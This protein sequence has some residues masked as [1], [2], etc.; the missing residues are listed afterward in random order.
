M[1]AV[2]NQNGCHVKL[3]EYLIYNDKV[4]HGTPEEKNEIN[5][6]MVDMKGKNRIS[7][8]DFGLFWANMVNMFK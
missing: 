6:K 2:M 7:E 5:F 8:D 3:R 4:Y 1:F